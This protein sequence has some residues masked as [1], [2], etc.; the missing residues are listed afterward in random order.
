MR[1]KSRA[2]VAALFEEQGAPATLL[3][4]AALSNNKLYKL[5]FIG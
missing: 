5:Y 3:L 1:F 4:S 2:F